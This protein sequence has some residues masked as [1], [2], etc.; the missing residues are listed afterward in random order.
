MRAINPDVE[1]I[2]HDLWLDASNVMDVIAPYD[3]IIEG[4]DN[5]PTKFLVNDACVLAGKPV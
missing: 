2:E 1:V 5:F 3:F 4:V